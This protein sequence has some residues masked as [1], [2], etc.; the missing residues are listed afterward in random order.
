MK[1]T[2]QKWGNSLALRI[3]RAVADELGVEQ[4]SLVEL[5]MTRR[6]LVIKPAK[7]TRSGLEELLVRVTPE[8]IHSEAD[9]GPPQGRESW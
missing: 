9:L 8:N 4:H 5:V 3:P 6:T 1:A 2:I 7:R